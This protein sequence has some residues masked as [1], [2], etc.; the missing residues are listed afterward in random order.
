MPVD[1][2]ACYIKRERGGFYTNYR[3]DAIRV[4]IIYLESK[5]LVKR[6]QRPGRGVDLV[7]LSEMAIQKIRDGHHSTDNNTTVDFDSV[8][9]L[10]PQGPE[11]PS[12]NIPTDTSE[13]SSTYHQ[14]TPTEITQVTAEAPHQQKQ[15]AISEQLAIHHRTT[16]SCEDNN[17]EN[18]P[19]PEIP[20]TI[21]DRSL[22]EAFAAVASGDMADLPDDEIWSEVT[23]L[24]EKVEHIAR[25]SSGHQLAANPC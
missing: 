17:Q 1:Q 5:G 2:L 25:S 24:G 14:P 20:K 18:N 7:H 22:V 11:A 21:S 9:K 3:N 15:Y 16:A 12:P 13:S 19:P 4:G 23:R 10:Y 6:V 8:N